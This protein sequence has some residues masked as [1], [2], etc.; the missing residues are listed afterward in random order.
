MSVPKRSAESAVA[1]IC[2]DIIN[3]LPITTKPRGPSLT[4]AHLCATLRHPEEIQV[5]MLP[6]RVRSM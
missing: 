2:H 4:L 5:V 6:V 3:S 1:F